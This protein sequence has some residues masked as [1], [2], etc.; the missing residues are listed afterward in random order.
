[1]QFFVNKLQL[2]AKE[3]NTEMHVGSKKAQVTMKQMLSGLNVAS[4]SGKL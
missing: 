3:Y 1:M 2:E 4:C